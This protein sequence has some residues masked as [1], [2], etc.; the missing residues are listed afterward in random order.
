MQSSVLTQRS[1]FP[2]EPVNIE[3][4]DYHK[5]LTQLRDDYEHEYHTIGFPMSFISP[6]PRML[7]KDH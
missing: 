3:I 6:L 4:K 2:Q 1:P 7:F 5:S